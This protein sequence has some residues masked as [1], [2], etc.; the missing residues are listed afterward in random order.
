MLPWELVVDQVGLI[1]GS[2]RF[3]L[4]QQSESE[5]FATLAKVVPPLVDLGGENELV[6]FV[7]A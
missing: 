7:R 1:L 3:L 4:W 5:R 6:R 2:D